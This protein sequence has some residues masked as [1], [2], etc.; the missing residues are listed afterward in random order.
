LPGDTLDIA[1]SDLLRERGDV[2]GVLWHL[3][4]TV[5]VDAPH[6]VADAAIYGFPMLSR[7]RVLGTLI[8]GL[9]EEALVFWVDE[10]PPQYRPLAFETVWG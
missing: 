1:R 5:F 9:P 7:K 4:D 6:T 8:K 3:Y 10:K 2:A